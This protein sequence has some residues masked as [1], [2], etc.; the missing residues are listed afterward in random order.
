MAPRVRRCGPG[1]VCYR[2]RGKYWRKG[3]G[4]VGIRR[5][6]K[7]WRFLVRSLFV[8]CRVLKSQL[9]NWRSSEFL[10]PLGFWD[11]FHVGRMDRLLKRIRFGCRGG[12]K[13]SCVDQSIEV[14]A[15]CCFEDIPGSSRRLRVGLGIQRSQCNKSVVKVNGFCRWVLS[16]YRVIVL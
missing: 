1:S 9:G 4:R 11:G 6:S 5:S 12:E 15:H 14:T 10:H 7:R 2:G 8:Q 3:R 16:C 13:E